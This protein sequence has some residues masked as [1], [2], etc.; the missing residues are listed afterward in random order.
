MRKNPQPR[1]RRE[2]GEE[3]AGICLALGEAGLR[4]LT[5]RD[6]LDGEQDPAP[7]VLISG[8]N[9][10][11]QLHVEAPPRESVV[12][13]VADEL[14]SPI[15]EVDKLLDVVLQHLVAEHHVETR[16]PARPAWPPRR[17]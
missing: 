14:G 8:Q 6:V 4:R 3:A 17:A 7:I 13:G 9:G 1:A 15:P 16:R 5:L 11:L 12:H 2:S 10:G